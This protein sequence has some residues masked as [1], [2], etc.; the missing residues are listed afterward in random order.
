MIVQ[1]EIIFKFISENWEYP[2]VDIRI[3][4]IIEVAYRDIDQKVK[5]TKGRFVEITHSPCNTNIKE[6]SN[7]KDILVLDT[8]KEFYSSQARI[9][10]SDIIYVEKDI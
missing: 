2:N 7:I 1:E 3:N 8:S 9:L 6:D 10:L 5:T 4:D